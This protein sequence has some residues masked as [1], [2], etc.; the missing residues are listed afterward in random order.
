MPDVR[1]TIVTGLPRAGTSMMMQML[2]AGG[3]DVLADDHRPPDDSNPRGYYEYAPVKQ[4]LTDMTWLHEAQ[5]KAVK[6]IHL[7]LPKLPDTCSYDV[8]FMHR[9][10]AEVVASQRTMLKRMGK[11]GGKLT[12]EQF[13]SIYTEQ[14]EKALQWATSQPNVRLLSVQ[15][16]DVIATPRTQAQRVETFLNRGQNVDAMAAAVDAKLYRTK[17]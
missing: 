16:H 3:H 6:V 4:S 8:I 17:V 11:P 12:D 10:L 7:L 15:Y 5:G 9:D 1:T 14:V 13:V 2:A